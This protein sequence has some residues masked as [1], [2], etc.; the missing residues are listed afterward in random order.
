[1][2]I[3]KISRN[4]VNILS[5]LLLSATV[6]CSAI[7]EEGFFPS[8]DGKLYIDEIS[9]SSVSAAAGTTERVTVYS[10][11]AWTATVDQTWVTLSDPASE[12]AGSNRISGKGRQEILLTFQAN[13]TASERAVTLTVTPDGEAEGVSSVST[14]LTQ[15]EPSFSVYPQEITDLAAYQP[16]QQTINITAINS[17]TLETESNWI[18]ADLTS[19]EATDGNAVVVTLT[20]DSN[21]G[22]G[23]R[24]GQVVVTSGDITQTVTVNQLNGQ[25]TLSNDTLAF[26]AEGGSQ[27]TDINCVGDWTCTITGYDWLTATPTSGTSGKTTITVTAKPNDTSSDREAIVNLSTNNQTIPLKV[28]QKAGTIILSQQSVSVD[29]GEHEIAIGVTCPGAWTVSTEGTAN[30][31][32]VQS[33]AGT[34]DNK[35]LMLKIAENTGE[36]R[37]T[38]FSVTFGSITQTVTVSQQRPARPEVGPIN[39]ISVGKQSVEAEATVTS[40]LDIL[41]SG[42]VY[43]AG[44]SDPET[45]PLRRKVPCEVIDGWM[46]GTITGLDE[47]ETYVIKAYIRTATYEIYGD[48]AKFNTNGL[49]PEDNDHPTPDIQ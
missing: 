17:W 47:M 34:S 41:E 12:S 37:T 39:V 19:G 21:F 16:E 45:D 46:R 49:I 23:P 48:P 2:K 14:V 3:N 20:F 8:D 4:C 42:F 40:S 26:E 27:S 32:T 10:N 28:T 44:L 35:Q 36:A 6:S 31:C 29:A 5:L 22:A 24:E 1:M 9:P 11:V 25:N 18:H 38:S 7:S 33:N 13:T 30:W 43:V 15:K